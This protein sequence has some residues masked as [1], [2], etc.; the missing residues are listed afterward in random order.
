M[1]SP[2]QMIICFQPW[3]PN[4]HNKWYVCAWVPS[5]FSHVRLCDPMDCSPSPG[6][7]AHE[8]LPGKNNGV[9][10]H[11]LLQRGLP[12]PGIETLFLGFL[13]QHAGSLPL[14]PPGKSNELY[15]VT[16]TK[17]KSRRQPLARLTQH[18]P[19]PDLCPSQHPGTSRGQAGMITAPCRVL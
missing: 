16:P 15:T 12:D 4:S 11:A 17:R 7:S 10:C 8:I 6:S 18:S 13:H 1:Q 9:G 3:S 19:Y 5:H 2:F 14:V